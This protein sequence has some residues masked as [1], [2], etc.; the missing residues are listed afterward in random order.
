MTPV[1]GDPREASPHSTPS[2]RGSGTATNFF[3]VLGRALTTQLED[4]PVTVCPS[5]MLTRRLLRERNESSESRP[6]MGAEL[7]TLWGWPR[8]RWA[9]HDQRE[10]NPL[11]LREARILDFDVKLPDS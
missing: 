11:S 8:P 4:Y 9:M 2:G 6:L 3:F 7:V 10:W 5:Q 1:S